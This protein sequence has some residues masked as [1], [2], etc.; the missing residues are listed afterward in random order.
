MK[1]YRLMTLPIVLVILMAIHSTALADSHADTIAVFKKSP[2]VQP[3]FESAYGYAVFPMVGKGGIIVGAAYGKGKVYRG[4]IATGTAELAKMTIGLQLGGQVF[5][6]I[7]FFKDQRA[8]DE[9]TSGSFEFDANASAVAIT[10]GAQA[11]AGSMGT[12]AG[13]SAGPA[14]GKQAGINYHKG[15]AIFVHAKGGLMFEAAIGGQQFTFE[16]YQ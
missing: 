2:A 14:T 13:A 12:T 4:G 10:A 1:R 16:P 9:F 5:S 15:M 3:F 7:V 6:Q 11:S 8:Y